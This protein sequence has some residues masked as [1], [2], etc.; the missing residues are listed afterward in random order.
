MGSV[1]NEHRPAGPILVQLVVGVVHGPVAL[2]LE[3]H[4]A[5]VRALRLPHRFKS[6]LSAWPSGGLL[7]IKH[8]RARVDMDSCP[9]SVFSTLGLEISPWEIAV[10]C[11][12]DDLG[13]RV[14]LHRVQFGGL[15]TASLS[16]V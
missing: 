10:G 13:R 9:T 12:F 4:A 15:V 14:G 5:Q 2:I 3:S 8:S 6:R 16:D 7:R 1:N 11:P